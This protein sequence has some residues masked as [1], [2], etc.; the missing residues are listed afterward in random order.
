[1]S[2]SKAWDWKKNENSIWFKPSEISYY[3]VNRWTELGYKDFLDFG[4]G[5]G[6]HSIHF[7]K[8]GFN[9]TSFDLSQDGVTHTTEWAKKENLKVTASTMDMLKLEYPKNSFD[10][11]FAYHVISHTTSK[12]ILKIIDEI[13]RVLKPSGEIYL[14]LCSKDTWAFKEAGFPKVDEKP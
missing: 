1:M 3:L 7:A 10:C 11:I 12:G 5:L 9:V 13:K 8:H 6:R 14:T 2:I 4:C